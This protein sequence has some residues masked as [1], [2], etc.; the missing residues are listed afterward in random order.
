MVRWG[1]PWLIWSHVVRWGHPRSIWSHVVGWNH[2]RSI[3]SHVVTL[4]PSGH[5][6][7]GEVTPGPSGHMWS[8]QVHL[9]TCVQALVTPGPSGQVWSL[10][11]LPYASRIK[12]TQTHDITATRPQ[13]ETMTLVY[14]KPYL[15]F[16]WTNTALCLHRFSQDSRS[17]NLFMFPL[18]PP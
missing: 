13:V 4:G 10:S 9:V 11:W 7:S 14:C 1:H 12:F 17:V 8:P 18:H 5:M 6:W 3:W 2:P 16:A 15:V